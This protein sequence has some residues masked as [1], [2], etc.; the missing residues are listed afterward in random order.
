MTNLTQTDWRQMHEFWRSLY[1]PCR[2]DEFPMQILTALPKVVGAELF[3]ATNF[4]DHNTTLPC[5]CSF[6]NPEIG[7]LA[8]QFIAQ[9]Q[10]FLAHPV[11]HHYARTV[12]GQALAISDF[13]SE[14]EFHQGLIYSDVFQLVG[15]ED[16]MAISL[17]LPAQLK[18]GS[19]C[20]PFHQGKEHL[21]LLVSRERR[22]FTERDRL[23]LNLIRPHLKQAYENVVAFDLLHQQ[24]SEH[25]EAIEQTA[26]I[27]LS[28]DGKV[29]WMTKLAGEIL[30]RYFPPSKARISLPDSL[31]RWV[32]HH[33]LPFSRSTEGLSTLRP[34]ILELNGRRLSVR[35]SCNMRLEE[36][37]LLLEETKPEK[38][39]IQSLQV[40]GLTKRES[41]VLFLIAK[42]QSTQ[43]IARHLGMS[44]RTVKKHIEHI[45]E[46]LGVQTRLGAVMYAL[47]KLGIAN[48]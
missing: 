44:D 40:L 46:K 43:E 23:I 14:S 28:A 3:A 32:D 25:Q 1:T 19:I 26:L 47:E 24:V 34:L 29:K 6:P 45:Y 21:S 22:G 9:P 20:D 42:D 8:E 18:T 38:F 48:L 11:A 16:Q 2:L 12:D 41:E 36:L 39:S 5:I 13:L 10:N 15:L 35:F 31:Q 17:K 37:Y 33:V 7:R 4:G 27:S 30:H